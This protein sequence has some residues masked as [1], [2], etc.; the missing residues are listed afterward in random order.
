MITGKYVNNHNG[1]IE[2]AQMCGKNVDKD[3]KCYLKN[4]KTKGGNSINNKNDPCRNN[5][6]M[7]KK[8]WRCR[9]CRSCTEKL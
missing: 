7:K 6:S 2:N 4:V 1:D 8:D 9:S 3:H 5:K